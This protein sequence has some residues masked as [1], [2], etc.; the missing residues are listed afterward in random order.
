MN[1]TLPFQGTVSF[2]KTEKKIIHVKHTKNIPF[3][4]ARKIVES[5][6][7]TRKYANIAQKTN[8]TPQDITPIDKYKKNL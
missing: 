6:I 5:Y 7:G 8:Q 4:E 1:N 3:P 2:Y